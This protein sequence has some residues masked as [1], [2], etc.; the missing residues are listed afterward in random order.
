M[1]VALLS[2][3]IGWL[4]YLVYSNIILYV[5]LFYLSCCLVFLFLIFVVVV[6][7]SH[8]KRRGNQMQGV[9]DHVASFQIRLQCNSQPSGLVWPVCPSA[10]ESQP[11]AGNDKC[12]ERMP[13]QR[14]DGRV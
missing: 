11:R 2:V 12:N 4:G 1:Y 8:L 6:V 10:L 9:K 7:L 13:A 14:Q 5:C 3:L